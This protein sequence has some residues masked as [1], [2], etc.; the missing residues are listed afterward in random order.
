MNEVQTTEANVGDIAAVDNRRGK[1]KCLLFLLNMSFT[2]GLFRGVLEEDA[3]VL[4]IIQ[5]IVLI[6]FAVMVL[7]WCHLDA[8]ERGFRISKPLSIAVVLLPI[9]AFPVYIFKTRDR[10]RTLWTLG[11]TALFYGLCLG[12]D[13]LGEWLGIIIYNAVHGYPILGG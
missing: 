13:Y 9:V 2:E 1:R 8:E 12:A 5:A 10:W 11:L 6:A 7:V 3:A 4:I